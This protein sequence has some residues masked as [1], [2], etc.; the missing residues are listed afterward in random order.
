[1]LDMPSSFYHGETGSWVFL[2]YLLCAEPKG[3]VTGKACVLIQNNLFMC[4]R[5]LVNAEPHQL[6]E[7]GG[8]NVRCNDWCARYV[9]KLIPGRSRRLYCL[10]ELVETRKMC[11]SALS[12]SQKDHGQFP[13]AA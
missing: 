11:P 2:T 1:M 4:S 9:N 13:Y 5:G 3:I 6:L 8:L 10:S 12:G 7:I